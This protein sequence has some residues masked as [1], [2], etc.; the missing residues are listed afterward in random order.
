MKRALIIGL[1]GLIGILGPI[2]AFGQTEVTE[3]PELGGRL[4]FNLN[5]KITK[6]WHVNLEEEVRFADNFSSFNRFHTTL[7]TSYKVQPNLKVGL[8]YALINGYNGTDKKFRTPHHRLFAEVTGSYRYGDWQFSLRERVHMTHRTD[9]FNEYQNPENAWMLK[10]R[11][12]VVYKGFRRWEPYGSIEMRNTLNAPVIKANYDGTNYV[13]DAGS[14]VGEAGWFLDG[15]NS[16][17]VNRWR[18]TLGVDYRIDR[19]S[20]LD[21]YL[22]ADYCSEKKVDAN[23]EGTKLKSYVLTKGFVGWICVGYSYSFKN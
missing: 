14:Q 6:G 18:G 17:Y 8:G 12:K 3:D 21:V 15:F 20:T 23:A 4:S 10:S 13:T 16:V 2:G 11:L 5:K 22:M 19:N 7:S 1:M 9:S